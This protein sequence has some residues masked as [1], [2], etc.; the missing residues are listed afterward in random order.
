MSNEAVI[1]DSARRA[2][3]IEAEALAAL[4]RALDHTFVAA[5]ERIRDCAGRLVVTGVGKSA[6]V[7]RKLAATFS[8]TGTPA[9]FM[10]AAEAAHGDLGMIVPGDLVLCLSKSG[11]TAELRALVPL[12]RD[13]GH[14]LLAIVC[15]AE[16]Y[17]ARQAAL[18]I[19]TPIR[20]EA[21]ADDLAPTTSTLVQ[22]AI[23]DAL[24]ASLAALRGF[25][26]ADFA[27][28][29]PGGALGQRLTLTL[30]DLACRNERPQVLATAALQD[31][32]VEMTGKRLG[33]TAVVEPDGRLLG[34]ITDGDLRRAI[35]RG[36]R[37]LRLSAKHLMTPTPRTLAP[38]Q[39]ASEGLR[40]LERH[41]FNHVV[42]ADADGTYRGMVHLHDFVREGMGEAAAAVAPVGPA[43]R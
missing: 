37:A 29:H 38:G 42:L 15:R 41:G 11:E 33:A 10:H 18:A 36:P 4:P 7:G 1:L 9:F 43:E 32:I 24:A 31:V 12:L 17:L 6:H 23:G 30:G 39:L 40:L 8:S 22:M 26:P 3:A 20:E 34:L 35:G 13:L 25:G 2:L 5:V 14:P 28:Y 27:R 19:V 21:D 16:S